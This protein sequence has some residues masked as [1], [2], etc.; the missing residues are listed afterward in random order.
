VKS[1]SLIRIL[2]FSYNMGQTEVILPDREI[3]PKGKGP[4]AMF[5]TATPN[6]FET[7][8]I[9]LI[10]GRFF[11]EHDRLDAPRVF[12]INQTMARRF[13]PD[14]DPIGKQIRTYEDD[15]SGVIIGVV[16]DAK[17]YQLDEEARPQMYDAYSQ[18]P[19]IF[20][21]VVVRTTVE[22][23]SL[24]EPIRQAVWKVDSDQPMWKVRTVESLI[25]RSVA[26]KRF[27]M[28]LMGVFATL[29]LALTVIGLY[30]V[31][32]YAV[33]QRAQEIGV[34]MALG[35][36][37]G[38]IHRMVLRQGMTL[39]LIGVAIGL[40]AAGLLTRLMAN[41]LFGVSATDLLTFGAIPSLLAIVALLA[42][43]IPSRRATKVD[44]LV[45]LRCE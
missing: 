1:V 22:P 7:M 34:R 29:A 25:D 31:M 39:V 24:A 8:G 6:Y 4:I 17:R 27:L 2:P 13:W 30:G 44:P 45:A 41:L 32:S 20:A 11:S 35:A 19:G 14:Q 37:A 40:A 5:N 33:S 42:C 26:D 9:P 12:I 18:S 38:A 43:L 3:P 16:G 15:L 28:V 10:K 23:M 36:G 21:T